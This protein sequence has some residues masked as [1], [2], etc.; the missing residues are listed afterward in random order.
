MK[1]WESSSLAGRFS[2]IQMVL[3]KSMK[4]PVPWLLSLLTWKDSLNSADFQIWISVIMVW[5]FIKVFGSLIFL[6]SSIYNF[7]YYRR[8]DFI[9]ELKGGRF[10]LFILCSLY[11]GITNLTGLNSVNCPIQSLFEI[12]VNAS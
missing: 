4:L 5:I 12:V 9:L 7:C 11:Q 10:L 2:L 8:N 3:F 1:C 6:W